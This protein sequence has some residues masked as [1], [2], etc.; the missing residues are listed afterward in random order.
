MHTLTESPLEQSVLSLV[1]DIDNNGYACISDYI[2]PPDL[3][4][5]QAFVTLAIERSGGHYASFKGAEEVAGS[6][7]DRMAHSLGFQNLMRCLYQAGTGKTAPDIG[8]YQ[9]LRCL[10]GKDAETHS[11]RFHYD[12]YVLT[13]LIPIEI[14][15]AGKKGDLLIIPST[16]KIRRNYLSNVFDKI[17][18]DNKLS[19]TL[20]KR[21]VKTSSRVVRISLL[22]GN[23]Y[24]FWGYRSIHTNEACDPENVRATALFHYADPHAGSRLKKMLQRH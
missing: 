10:S 14:P 19:Q 2:P 18:L 23:I 11:L 3:E 20:L 22:P 4:S 9:I 17:L 1:R 8:F 24:F 7:L 13:A 6:T 5:M 15:T 12:S 16:R 21:Y